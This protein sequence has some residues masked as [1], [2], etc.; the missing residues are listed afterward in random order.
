MRA[1]AAEIA[2]GGASRVVVRELEGY[3]RGLAPGEV[4]ALLRE[5]FARAGVAV[6]EAPGEAAALE[7]ALAGARPGDVVALFP[8]LDAQ[9]V[10]AVI[11]A[12]RR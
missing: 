7:R 8:L 11:D 12:A 5:A 9:G 3:L 10:R 6:D 4:P 1:V 2:A